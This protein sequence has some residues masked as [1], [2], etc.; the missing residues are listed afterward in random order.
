MGE[1]EYNMKIDDLNLPVDEL[2]QVSICSNLVWT[3][4]ARGMGE[5]ERSLGLAIRE[6]TIGN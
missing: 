1:Q 3:P 2:V 6:V 5:D 4:K